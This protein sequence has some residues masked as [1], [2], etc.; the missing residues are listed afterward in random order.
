MSD[1]NYQPPR[2]ELTPKAP[3]SKRNIHGQWIEVKEDDVDAI[4]N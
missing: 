4:R 1:P 2:F 3:G